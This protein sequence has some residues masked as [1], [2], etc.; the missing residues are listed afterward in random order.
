[1]NFEI[2]FLHFFP[3][4]W[5]KEIVFL[6]SSGQNEIF[7]HFAT[8]GKIT[9]DVHVLHS[10]ILHVKHGE[11]PQ[12]RIQLIFRGGTIIWSRAWQDE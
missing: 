12:G 11:K 6:A 5:P 7:P 4:V 2:F 10:T 8:P 1:V 3:I 9:F